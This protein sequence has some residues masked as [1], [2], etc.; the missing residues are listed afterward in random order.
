MVKTTYT[1]TINY[2]KYANLSHIFL[3]LSIA[4]TTPLYFIDKLNYVLL[5]LG[6][7]S[8]IAF[9]YLTFMLSKTKLKEITLKDES[10]HLNSEFQDENSVI[11]FKDVNAVVINPNQETPIYFKL[12]RYLGKSSITTLEIYGNQSTILVYIT[13]SSE[14]NA[15]QVSEQISQWK[16]SNFKHIFHKDS[17]NSQG[18]LS[19]QLTV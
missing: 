5:F 19:N 4:F 16:S 10:I 14:V 6:A 12:M 11:N 17:L 3:S 9:L 1:D 8:W 18:N 2:F 7:I 13:P 15:N